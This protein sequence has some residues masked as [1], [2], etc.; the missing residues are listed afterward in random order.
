[1]LDLFAGTGALGLEA[2]SRGASAIWLVDKHR[3]ALQ[4]I[5]ANI[6]T[7]T[8]ALSRA[9]AFTT[10]ASTVSSFLRSEPTTQADLV[11]IDPP[12]DLEDAELNQVLQ[13]LVP[14]LDS[15]AWVIVER[16]SRSSEPA[17]PAGLDPLPEKTYGDTTLYV[18]VAGEKGSQPPLS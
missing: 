16:S 15:G 5:R 4:V 3:G 2:A 14:W 10:I 6:A 8:T 9:V 1:M 11:F 12:Y 13:D 18:A 17:W 7:L